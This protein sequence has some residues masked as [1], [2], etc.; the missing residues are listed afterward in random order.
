MT[1]VDSKTFWT[2]LWTG[3]EK[4][5]ESLRIGEY[6][7]AKINDKWGVMRD[8]AEYPTGQKF[9]THQTAIDWMVHM[10]CNKFSREER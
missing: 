3:A 7:S 8:G 1:I 10:E 5:G 2:S 6:R 4:D 9:D